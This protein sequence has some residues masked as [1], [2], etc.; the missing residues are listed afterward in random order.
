MIR[1]EKYIMGK[2]LEYYWGG[3]RGCFNRPHLSDLG[4][5]SVV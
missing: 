1:L 2:P 4:G 5:P 3:G